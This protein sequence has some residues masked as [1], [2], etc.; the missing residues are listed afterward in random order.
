MARRR[1]LEAPDPKALAEIEAGFAAKP[2]T[3]PGGFAAPIAQVAAEAASGRDARPAPDR[4]EAAR[5]ASQAAAWREAQAE[6]RLIE[7]L[8]LD[9][10]QVNHLSRD[11]IETDAEA[12]EELT[13][14]IR[15]NGQRLPIEVMDLGEGRYGLI[16]GWRRM[17]ALALI[18]AEDGTAPVARAIVRP[19]VEAGA[20]YAA[21]VEENE[22]RAQLTPYE[23]G[24]I[25]AVAA[26]LGAFPSMEAA[27]DEIFA[28]ASKAKRSKIR[29]FALVHYELGDLLSHGRALSEAAGLRLA[30]ALRGG[31]AA[32]L[33]AALER[34]EARDA[35]E[36]WAALEAV[37][38]SAEAA[39][40][41]RQRGGRPRRDA[42]PPLAEARLADGAR[43][44]VRG[45]GAKL[46]L[47]LDGQE[48]LDEAAR[49]A[50]AERMLELVEQALRG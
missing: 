16:S 18:G 50:L 14:S 15:A 21:M 37:L 11:R 5:V 42:P 25:A 17:R 19:V 34:C 49:Q 8:P 10:I 48:G 20:A 13:A 35:A 45:E 30:S 6:G 23:R 47:T 32:K 44:V 22:V 12:M 24:R 33:R 31:F 46:V 38:A 29:S 27:V 43:A 7:T 4:A 9:R 36:E 41:P 2:M 3:G 1:T 26:H 28:A 40:A 39:P